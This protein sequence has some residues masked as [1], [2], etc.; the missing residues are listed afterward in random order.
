M[1][2]STQHGEATTRDTSAS[3]GDSSLTLSMWSASSESAGGLP[4]YTLARGPKTAYYVNDPTLWGRLYKQDETNPAI[5]AAI[6]K[7]S[8]GLYLYHNACKCESLTHCGHI[9][10]IQ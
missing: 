6:N 10:P 3:C 2:G 5:A 1:D 8:D 7:A 9:D 4:A